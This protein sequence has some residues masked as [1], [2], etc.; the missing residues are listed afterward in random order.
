MRNR[1][2]QPP[3]GEPPPLRPVLQPTHVPSLG[4]RRRRGA[5]PPAR[6]FGFLLGLVQMVIWMYYDSPWTLTAGGAVV[7]YITNWRAAELAVSL[8]DK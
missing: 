4:P 5:R 7:G 1:K 3:W 2:A 6:R 8:V